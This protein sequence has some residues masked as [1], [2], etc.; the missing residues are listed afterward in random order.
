MPELDGVS[1]LEQIKADPHLQ[2]VPVIMISAIDEIDSV[3]RCIEMGA[4]DYLPKPFDPVLLRA[5]INAGLARKRLHDLEQERVRSVFSRFVPEHVVEDVLERTDDDL[6]L[7]GSRDV[8]TVMFTDIRGFTAFTEQAQPQQV[9]ELLERVL[10]RDDRCDLRAARHVGRLSRRRPAWRSSARRSRLTTTPITRSRRLGRCSK[11]ACLASTA[12]ARP[13]ASA[14]HSR[15][16]SASQRAVHVRQRRLGARA[17]VHG[18]RR[19]RQHRRSP[20]GDDEDRSAFASHG[21]IDLPGASTRPRTPTSWASSRSGDGGPPSASGHWVRY[22]RAALQPGHEGGGAQ[23]A[24]LFEGLSK[25]ELAQLARVSEEYSEVPAG[26]VICREGD[27]GREFFV[28]VEGE[29][30]VTVKARGRRA[31]RRRL[32]RPRSRCSKT[33]AERPP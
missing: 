33:Q 22:P 27:T 2:H 15:W 30:E 24:P 20:G 21:R 9:I 32:R 10:Q 6:R 12:G 28:I 8:G 17:G 16:E 14:S 3:V 7:G 11:C 25:K 18:P 19:H 1:A 29:I 26:D 5:R 31:R 13:R 4:E 23:R